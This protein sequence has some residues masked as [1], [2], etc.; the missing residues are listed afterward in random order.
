MGKQQVIPRQERKLVEEHRRTDRQLQ[1]RGAI[2]TQKDSLQGLTV[3]RGETA[4]KLP[5]SLLQTAP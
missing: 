4:E 5:F 1:G 3:L 2:G